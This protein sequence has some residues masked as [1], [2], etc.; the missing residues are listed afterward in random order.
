[1]RSVTKEKLFYKESCNIASDYLYV[2]IVVL[3][4]YDALYSYRWLPTFRRDLYPLSSTLKMATTG[5]SEELVT[6]YKTTRRHNPYVHYPDFYRR[7][8]LKCVAYLCPFC[9]HFI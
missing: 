4:G 8:K 5:S 1:V 3:R 9:F 2:C 7:E 6:T